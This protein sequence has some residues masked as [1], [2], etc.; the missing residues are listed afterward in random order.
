MHQRITGLAD[1]SGKP[2]I[3][4]PRKFGTPPWAVARQLSG[5]VGA[6][7]TRATYSWHVARTSLPGAYQRLLD[8]VAGRPGRR[9]SS[10]G[11]RWCPATSCSS[12]TRPRAAPSTSTTPPAAGS[13]ELDRLAF[14]GSRDRHRRL[15]RRRGSWSR[16]T[17]D[18]DPAPG[19]SAP[20]R[21]RTYPLRVATMSMN[22]VIHAA[23]RRDL[24]RFLGALSR[25]P[26]GDAAR[27]E[28]A[29]TGVGQLRL[30]ADQAPRGRARDRL[31][32]AGPG[33]RDAADDRPDGRRARGDGRAAVGRP[34][35]DGR[36]ARR[37][38]AANA[39]TAHTAMG[40]LKTVTIEHLDHEER[41]LEPVYQAKKD[42]PAIKEMGKK[43]SKVPPKEGGVFFAWVTDGISPGGARRASTRPSPRRSA[44]SSAACWA[45]RTRRTSPR[46]G[47]ELPTGRRARRTR[48]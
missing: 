42:D 47:V 4:W 23:F 17:P 37:P 38:T 28:A 43:F 19:P 48:A 8:A 32:R 15:G 41:E 31:A 2:Q 12:S 9:R 13:S 3:P 46:S 16:P 1:V 7:G 30:P 18:R 11:A 6:D 27:A 20:A 29:R 44:R 36:P 10:S 14:L 26:D 34:R 25:F 40:E 45:G 39:Q 21:A 22:K 35:L 24:D 33:R 5:T